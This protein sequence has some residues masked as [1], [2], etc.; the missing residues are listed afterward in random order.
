[1]LLNCVVLNC[2]TSLFVLRGKNNKT[3][4]IKQVHNFACSFDSLSP[5]FVPFF[6][7]HL[8]KSNLILGVHIFSL[9]EFYN[10][11]K[12][13]RFVGFFMCVYSPRSQVRTQN[14][15]FTTA[16]NVKH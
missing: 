4:D 14:V 15:Q 8:L 16:T 13:Q 2:L 10:Y 3:K 7:L 6:M 11:C 12:L 1:M 9:K 5:R